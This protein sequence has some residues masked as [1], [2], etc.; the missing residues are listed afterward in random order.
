MKKILFIILITIIVIIISIMVNY[1]TDY[2]I[3]FGDYN[4]KYVYKYNDTRIEDIIDDI[5]N[6]IKIKDKY[7]QNLL[8]KSNN[9]YINLNNL[10]ISNHTNMNIEELLITIRKYSKEKIIVILRNE[11]K[12]IDKTINNMIFKIREKYDILIMR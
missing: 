8:V 9:I 4:N 11:D 2:N 10:Y 6:N 3:Y 1:K 5:E 12:I 7:I